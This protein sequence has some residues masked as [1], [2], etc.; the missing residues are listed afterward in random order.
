VHKLHYETVL[1]MQGGG[2]LGAY[3]CG[4][5][6]ALAR[7]G[8]KFDIIAGTSIGA[9]NAG[10][11]AGSK[12]GRPEKD[13]EDFWLDVAETMTP[14]VVPDNL[15]AVISSFYGAIY[16][17]LKVFSPVWPMV[18]NI[19]GGV[20]KLPYLYDLAALKGTLQKYIDFA[21]LKGSTPRFIATCTDIKDGESV[22]FDSARMDIDADHLVA[23]AS[24]PFY[25]I[26]WTEKDGRY[27]WDG[28][29]L[30][31]TPLREVI[32]SS[33]KNDK[34][35]YIVNLFPHLQEELPENLLDS[36][37]RARDIMYIDKTDQNLRMSKI[38]S[39]YLLLLKEMHD[40]IDS[41]QLDPESQVRFS[42][43]QQE[44]YKLAQQR[45]AI[46]DEI[47]RI[48]RSEDVHYL[49]EDADFSETTIKKL[50]SQGEEDA[51]KELAKKKQQ[52]AI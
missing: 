9:V 2:S 45:G 42:K 41:V 24:Y 34:R 30:S 16:G 25:G 40:I 44:Y 23:C 52:S 13:L 48:E 10:I 1:V 31:N 49:F 14:S 4:V 12:S 6:K 15:R 38:I 5:Y 21:K 28:A 19:N 51:E 17:N 35:V 39:K 43:I 7:H 18:P 46:I 3:E 20:Y 29:L 32:D 26:A 33:P 22:V 8:I 27:L 11:V 36:W 47:V 37:H 50:I